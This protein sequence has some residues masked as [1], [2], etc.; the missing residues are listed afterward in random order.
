MIKRKKKFFVFAM[1]ISIIS[2]A[3]LY[4]L[5]IALFLKK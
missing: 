3:G 4:W 2:L 5:A 1:L